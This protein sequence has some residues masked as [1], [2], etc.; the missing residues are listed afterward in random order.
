LSEPVAEDKYTN[1]KRAIVFINIFALTI[2]IIGMVFRKAVE[3]GVSTI[4]FAVSRVWTLF[5]TM[6]IINLYKQ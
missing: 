3:N 2:P 4:D 1:R 5:F 6:S